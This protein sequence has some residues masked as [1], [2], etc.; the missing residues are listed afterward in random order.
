MSAT[1]SPSWAGWNAPGVPGLSGPT[2][3]CSHQPPVQITS[4]A[5][6][7]DVADAEAVREPKG[8]GDDLAGAARLAD[9]VHLPRLDGIAAGCEPGH[10]AFVVL[11]LGLPAHHEHAMAV[12]E[13]IGVE[14]RLVAGAVPDLVLRPVAAALP[15][16]FSYQ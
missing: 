13:K 3:G 9:R 1:A 2:G 16:G 12:A 11:A 5:V 8:A 15:L 14:R 6:A 7:V 4:A 10:L